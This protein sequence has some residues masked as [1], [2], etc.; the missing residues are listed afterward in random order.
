MAERQRLRRHDQGRPLERRAFDVSLGSSKGQPLEPSL[1]AAL[2]P[3]FGHSFERVRVHADAEADRLSRESAA[4]ALTHGNDVFFRLGEYAPGTP[5]GQHLLAHELAHVVQRDRFGAPGNLETSRANDASEVE[6]RAAADAVVAGGTPSFS[7]APTA[8]ISRD[9]DERGL[10]FQALPPR[11]QYGFGLGGGSGNAN[12]S[13]GGLGLEYQR[14]MFHGETNLGYGGSAG[15][16][17]GVGAPLQ[18]WLMDVNRDMGQASGAINSIMNGGLMGPNLSGLGG[19]GTLGDVA[20]AGKPSPYS[21]GA[22]LQLS[23]SS[24][25][26]RVMLGAGVNF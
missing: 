13:L 15:L 25:E 17:L 5:E 7:S 2:E 11:L 6:A 10:S 19:L 24:D 3:R 23:H 12:L 21:W 1:R 4:R 22:G 18:P 14:G 26:D 16:N 8:G 20:A 9:D